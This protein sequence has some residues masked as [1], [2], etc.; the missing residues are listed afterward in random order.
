MTLG[1]LFEKYGHAEVFAVE[2]SILK[3]YHENNW[4][5]LAHDEVEKKLR[6]IGEFIPR[7]R[8]EID[9]SYR[10]II[11]YCVILCNE[12]I[13]ATRRLDGDERLVGKYSIGIGGHIEKKDGEGQNIIRQGLYR[14]LNEE[15]LIGAQVKNLEILG[16]I[17][18]NESSVDSVHYGIAYGIHLDSFDVEVKEKDVLE[19]QWY[20]KSELNAIK[21]YLENWSLYCLEHFL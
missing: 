21:E 15:L 18:M 1:K 10:Q 13:F 14:E 16:Y 3:P 5:E 6:D 7:Y 9:R 11:P 2:D 19:G 4:G 17:Y 20:T 8:A 12:K